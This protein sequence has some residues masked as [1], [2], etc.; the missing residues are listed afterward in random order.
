MGTIAAREF[1]SIGI[2]IFSAVL[3]FLTIIFS[4]VIPKNVGDR[5]NHKIFPAVAGF[6]WLLSKILLPLV[7]VLEFIAKP[8]TVGVSPFLTSEEE[9]TMLTSEGAKEGSIEPHEKAVGVVGLENV[10]EELVGEII[11]E[12]DVAPELIKRVSKNEVIVHGQTRV[13]TFNH[14]FNT[15]IKSRKTINDFLVESF[16]RVPEEGEVVEV[17]N[18]SFKIEASNG[19]QIKR[20]RVVKNQV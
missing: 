9:I 16:G 14:F 15:D 2:G 7:K 8:F 1:S 17:N 19:L 13:S 20:V 5:W 10:L 12:K 3:T 11:D 4:E 18:L 6:L